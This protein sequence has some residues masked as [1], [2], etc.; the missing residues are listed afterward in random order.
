MK[1]NLTVGN[2]SVEWEDR[3]TL[4]YSENGF[5]ALVW[6]DYEP[7]IFS[8]GRIIK[9][10]SIVKWNAKP[11]GTSDH[12]EPGQKQKIISEIQKFFASRG[13]KCT[14]QADD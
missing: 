10:A 6:V 9:S 12:I 14:V 2:S 3:E 5:S 13:K 7:G 8:Q 4:R 11:E 1:S